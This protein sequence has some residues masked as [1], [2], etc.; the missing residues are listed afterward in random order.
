MSRRR[1]VEAGL[2]GQFWLALAAAP[3]AVDDWQLGQFA[4][5]LTYGIFAMSL[6]A[7][8][9]RL[10]LLSFGHAV[11]FG[12][13]AYAM[14]LVTLGKLPWLGAAPSAWLGL[15]AAL[16]LPALL[17]NLLGRLLFY[18]RGLRGAYFGIVTLAIAVVAERLAV[19]WRFLGGFNGLMNVPPLGIGIAG[20]QPDPYDPVAGY[21]LALAVALLVWAGLAALLATPFGTVLAAI[22]ENEERVA[23][24]GYDVAQ[25][26]L[27]AFTVSAAVAGLA[28]AL[29]VTQFGFVQPSLLGFALS[30]EVLI[31]VGLGGREGLL[32]AFLGALAVHYADSTLSELFDK[33][34]WP[35]ALGLGFVAVVIFLPRGLFGEPLARLQARLSRRQDAPPGRRH[36]M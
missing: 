5:Y 26:K 20:W 9:G 16:A 22:R 32:T 17:A 1:A 2:A 10:D 14:S 24:L 30:T 31:W 33:D 11:F 28:G 13:G 6:A 25:C 36:D 12:A 29:F 19:N 27:A 4:Q 3:L 23:S 15:A 7:I 34:W 21:Y 35:L 18:G 8:W